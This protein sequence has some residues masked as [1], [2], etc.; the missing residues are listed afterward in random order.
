[1]SPILIPLTAI[2][3]PAFLVPT[4]MV[5]KQRHQKRHWQHLERMKA[6]AN[7]VP[8]P[9][10][11]SPPGSG[12][13]IAIGAGVPALA[14]FGAFLSTMHIEHYMPHALERM[15]IAWAFALIISMG[16]MTTSLILFVLQHRAH[17]RATA[18]AAASY[19]QAHY[20]STKP[21]YDP[22]AFDVV[23]RRG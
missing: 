3:L 17:A 11:G 2:T 7:G 10:S 6:I 8:V 15:A 22:D 13:V 1:V 12:A 4:L 9:P 5:L 19:V 14:I 16:G 18:E 21:A 23:A 20:D